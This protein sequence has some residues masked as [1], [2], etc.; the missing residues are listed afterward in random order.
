[1]N[2]EYNDGGR[3]AAGHKGTT[4][5]CVV[6]AIAIVTGKPYTEI[7]Q[8]INLLGKKER[9]G[10]KKKSKSNARTGV[11]KTTIRAYLEELGLHWTPTM[12]VGSGCTVHLK[13]NE[14]PKGKLL[15]SVSRHLTAVIDGIIY[16]THDCSREGTRCVYGYWH[17]PVS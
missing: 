10:R 8:A 6:R 14:L 12:K 3:A 9:I 2:W 11:Y 15:V 4:G 16:D 1:M 7:Y 17:Y 13:A 5:D